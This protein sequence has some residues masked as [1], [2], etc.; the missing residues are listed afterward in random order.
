MNDEKIIEIND[1]E[2][3]HGYR[4]SIDDIQRCKLASV[5]RLLAKYNFAYSVYNHVTVCYFKSKYFEKFKIYNGHLL[6][7]QGT[8]I[9]RKYSYQSIWFGLRR[10]HSFEFD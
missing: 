5:C 10:S 2:L 8:N 7:I 1:L 9:R 3:S 6:T 4:K